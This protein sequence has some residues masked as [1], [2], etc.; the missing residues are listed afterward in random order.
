LRGKYASD[1]GESGRLCKR[2]GDWMKE[3]KEK[4]KKKKMNKERKRKMKKKKEKKGRW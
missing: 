3:K 2:I 4:M 1:G